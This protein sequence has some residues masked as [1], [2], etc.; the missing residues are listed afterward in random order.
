[1]LS[2]ATQPPSVR[3]RSSTTTSLHRLTPLSV[4]RGW[5][6]V[7][8]R[9]PPCASPMRTSS[10]SRP[11]DDVAYMRGSC[12]GS[13]QIADTQVANGALAAT[14]MSTRVDASTQQQPFILAPPYLYYYL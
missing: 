4:N 12:F 11:F 7:A 5:F 1:M 13:Y 3:S 10:G 9:L 6:P 2:M 14:A 8:T